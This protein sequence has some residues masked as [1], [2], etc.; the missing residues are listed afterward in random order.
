MD[1][2]IGFLRVK[3]IFSRGNYDRHLNKQKSDV[4]ERILI[5]KSNTRVHSVPLQ[6]L[7]GASVD[8]YEC[9]RNEISYETTYYIVIC[10]CATCLLNYLAYH[11]LNIVCALAYADDNFSCPDSLCCLKNC[12]RYAMCTHNI[13]TYSRSCIVNR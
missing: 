12:S 3:L 1:F 4:S 5:T 8:E 13:T 7:G 2:D 9:F 11:M 10:R 6:P